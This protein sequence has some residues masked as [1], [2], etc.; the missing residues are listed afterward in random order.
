MR[1]PHGSAASRLELLE[2]LLLDPF[3]FAWPGA[4]R[5]HFVWEITCGYTCT[6]II[7]AC[8]SGI[9]LNSKL[10]L[11]FSTLL[12]NNQLKPGGVGWLM[13]RIALLI[14]TCVTVYMVP[15]SIAFCCS[16]FHSHCDMFA[17][18]HQM[19]WACQRLC[20]FCRGWCVCRQ[21]LH[22]VRSVLSVLLAMLA[23]V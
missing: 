14:P 22:H 13:F 15:L 5:C 12:Q 19:H 3:D 16:N 6:C 7:C 8:Y 4:V 17:E 18:Q 1:T 11:L 9:W 20:S 10:Q 21:P 23:C 2:T